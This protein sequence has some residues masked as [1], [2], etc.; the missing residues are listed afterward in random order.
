MHAAQCC[1]GSISPASG[2]YL[3]RSCCLHCT[4]PEPAHHPAAPCALPL[5]PQLPRQIP[6]FQGRS[7]PFQGRS[8]PFHG[9]SLQHPPV[10]CCLFCAFRGTSFITL[11]TFQ[12][13]SISISLCL[14]AFQ[15]TFPSISLCPATLLDCCKK[16]C[17]C[18]TLHSPVPF[19]K[20][21]PSF[22]CAYCKSHPFCVCP[23]ALSGYFPV[24]LEALLEGTVGHSRLPIYQVGCL[25]VWQ[26]WA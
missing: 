18:Y 3:G 23:A 1:F 26:G 7:P 19:F 4:L 11:C 14:C 16:H 2:H 20:A 6:P 13:T 5:T 9:R 12:G 25:I 15:G 21:Y 24:K 17:A 10:P 22:P 8:P